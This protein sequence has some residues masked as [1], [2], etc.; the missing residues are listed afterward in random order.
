M[1]PRRL[2][3]LL[4]VII[5]TGLCL[6]L[7][8]PSLQRDEPLVESTALNTDPSELNVTIR[9]DWERRLLENDYSILSET[10]IERDVELPESVQVHRFTRRINEVIEL[11]PGW[12]EGIFDLVPPSY[13]LEP[14]GPDVWKGTWDLVP[15]S[16]WLEPNGPDV[17]KGMWDLVPR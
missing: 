15:P 1:S 14:N 2:L 11:S 8:L 12:P 9:L 17:W 3:P 13:W 4:A 16:Y 5:V 6:Y 10:R 7:C